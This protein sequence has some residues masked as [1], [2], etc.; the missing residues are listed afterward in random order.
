MGFS[1]I[2]VYERHRTAYLSD[3]SKVLLSVPT[4]TTQ[5]HSCTSN[6]VKCWELRSSQSFKTAAHS[7]NLVWGGVAHRRRKRLICPCPGGFP[8]GKG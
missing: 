5:W 1:L 4:S 2:P 6:W 3:L 7:L 8:N